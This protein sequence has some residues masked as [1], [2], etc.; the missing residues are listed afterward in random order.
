[1]TLAQS[2][3]RYSARAGSAPTRRKCTTQAPLGVLPAFP[4]RFPLPV[5]RCASLWPWEER[6]AVGQRRRGAHA[7]RGRRRRRRGKMADGRAEGEKARR[8]PPAGGE[9][10]APLAA[11]PWGALGP[12]ASPGGGGGAGSAALG[13]AGR[14]GP[15]RAAPCARPWGEG[16]PG[17]EGLRGRGSRGLGTAPGAASASRQRL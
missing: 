3:G 15:G 6:E 14:P 4:S 12:G 16:R 2:A 17:P 13:W 8:P 11:G 10:A 5:H 1:M 9:R 7:Q